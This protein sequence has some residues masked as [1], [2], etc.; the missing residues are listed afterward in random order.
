MCYG[1][2]SDRL[3]VAALAKLKKQSTSEYILAVI[4]AQ[5]AAVYGATPPESL[6]VDQRSTA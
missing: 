3:R 4:R 5:Y 1:S 6:D 2:Q